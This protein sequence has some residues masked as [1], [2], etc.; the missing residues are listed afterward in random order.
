MLKPMG[1]TWAVVTGGSSGLG[2]AFAKRL[3]AEG[4]DIWLAARREDKLW[5][6]AEAL[7]SEYGVAT[8]ISVVD[9]SDGASRA[10]FSAELAGARVSHLVNN[11]GFAQLGSFAEADSAGTTAMLETNMVAVTELM[12]AVLPG[13]RERARGA[14]INVAS[15][16]AFQP[17]PNMSAYAATKA[18]VLRLSVGVREELKG[19]GV[20]VI[21]TCPGPIETDFWE[22]G[23]ND[24]M[25]RSR[26][27]P[28]HVV[29]AT[30]DGL[31]R[32]RPFVLDTAASK[33]MA[34]ATRLAPLGLQASIAAWV[35]SR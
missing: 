11:A 15:V 5:D 26:V 32:N 33:A 2:V 14:I 24:D 29:D 3:A 4:A 17:T 20:R 6:V 28:E 31:R 18:Y 25:M 19:S 23:G 22:V 30:M 8:R 12:H 35:T 9:L 21:A 10:A 16:A 7:E 34:F 13:M 1:N 27:S